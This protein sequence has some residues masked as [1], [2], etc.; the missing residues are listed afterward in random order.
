MRWRAPPPARRESPLAGRAGADLDR[1]PRSNPYA[2][3][4]GWWTSFTL[5]SS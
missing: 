1:P 5:A 3:L 4:Q 2:R